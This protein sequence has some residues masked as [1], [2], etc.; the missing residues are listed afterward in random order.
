MFHRREAKRSHARDYSYAIYLSRP[1]AGSS[2]VWVNLVVNSVPIL[3]DDD[4][5]VV[6]GI[7]RLG[8]DEVRLGLTCLGVGT[9][10]DLHSCV[11]AGALHVVTHP[12]SP[13]TGCLACHQP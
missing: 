6:V 11:R 1:V 3:V 8:D 9:C 7:P 10:V 4:V 5:L 2:V 12:R 13:F